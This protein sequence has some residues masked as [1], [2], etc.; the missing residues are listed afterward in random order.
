[1]AK[2]SLPSISSSLPP[3]VRQ[4]LQ[5][6]REYINAN[7]DPVSKEDLVSSGIIVI[8]NYGAVTAPANGVADN[9]TPP[10]PFG[11][12]ATAGITSIALS[13][14]S[15]LGFALFDHAEIYRGVTSDITQ[16]ISVGTSISNTWSDAVAQGTAYHYWVRFVSTKGVV[17]PFSS[18]TGLYV[19]TDVDTQYFLDTLNGALTSSELSVALS[20]RITASEAMV[21]EVAA[22]KGLYTVKIDNDGYVAG[23]GL[24]SGLLAGSPYSE[25]QI[26]ADKFVLAPPSG[27]DVA[28]EK[29]PFY[30]LTTSQT[31]DDGTTLAPGMYLDNAF[32]GKL[33]AGQI[34]TRGLTIKDSAG[35]VIFGAGVS[36]PVSTISGLGTLATSNSVTAS[37]V[38]GLGSLALQDAVSAYSVSGLSTY[39]QSVGIDFAMINNVVIGNAN[40]NNLTLDGTKLQ[41][42]AIS[43]VYSASSGN[44]LLTAQPSTPIV[45][46]TGVEVPDSST[47]VM[48]IF[49]ASYSNA[50]ASTRAIASFA[51]KRNNGYI[52]D[53]TGY[54]STLFSINTGGGDTVVI[55]RTIFDTNP[56][57]GTNSY[58]INPR[59]TWGISAAGNLQLSDIALFAVTFKR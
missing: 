59:S 11:L 51:M 44:I 38:S 53:I 16:A 6:V 47:G 28:K 30:Y 37:N 7:N 42:H 24:M 33:T 45:E 55:S 49:C 34:D 1:M 48:L 5:R 36:I 19:E 46:V 18:E 17:G 23:F 50:N 27:S 39:I 40:I 13:W 2:F 15:P 12:T 8:N 35:S 54:G 31:Q 43:R 57:I 52:I 10:K 22:I 9:S 3:D 20:D 32:V 29:S 14:V 25:F 41:A 56:L 58:Q 21:P 26:R 4:F